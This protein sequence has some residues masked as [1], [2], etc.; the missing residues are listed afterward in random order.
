MCQLSD[1]SFST[2][3][4]FVTLAPWVGTWQY[5]EKVFIVTLEAGGQW[6]KARKPAVPRTVPKKSESKPQCQCARERVLL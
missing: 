2:K 4:G 1:E 3:G 5:L 6:V